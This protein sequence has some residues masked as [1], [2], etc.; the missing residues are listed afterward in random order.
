[1]FKQIG[2]LK[3]GEFMRQRPAQSGGF[4]EGIDVNQKSFG[5]TITDFVM[6]V[7]DQQV[8]S[9]EKVTD[10]IQGR[11]DN[12]HEAMISATEAKISFQLMLEIRNRLLEAYNE[13][14]KMQI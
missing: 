9:A 1:M 14:E 5:D 6:N 12:L 10:V 13:I 3:L 2:T 7:N 4:Q 11:S 8:T